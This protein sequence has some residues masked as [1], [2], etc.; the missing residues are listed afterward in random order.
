VPG[1]ASQYPWAAL[2]TLGGPLL[3]IVSPYLKSWVPRLPLVTFYAFYPAHLFV[4]WF[5]HGPY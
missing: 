4:I 5:I 1:P 2:T 3:I